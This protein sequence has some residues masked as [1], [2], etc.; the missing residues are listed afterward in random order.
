M[1]EIPIIGKNFD[2]FF[3]F[4]VNLNRNEHKFEFFFILFF[5]YVFK[6]LKNILSGPQTTQKEV[7]SDEEMAVENTQGESKGGWERV[8][9]AQDELKPDENNDDV[10]ITII[11][12]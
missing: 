3:F 7:E 10:C 9:I 8:E 5:Y 4:F 12:S 6:L 1:G 2:L 11:K